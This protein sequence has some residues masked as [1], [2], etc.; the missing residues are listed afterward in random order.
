MDDLEDET[1]RYKNESQR[2]SSEIVRLQNEIQNELFLKSSCEVEKLTIEDDLTTLKHLRK[3]YL[4]LNHLIFQVLTSIDEVNLAELR[5]KSLSNDLD[6]SKFFRNEL[7]EAIR[8]IRNDYET[9]VDNRRNDLQN[10]YSL[11]VN[12]TITRTQQRDANPLFNQQQR[13]QVERL[14]NELVQTLDQN[15]YLRNTNHDMQNS[16]ADLKQKIKDFNDAGR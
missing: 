7:S 4:F 10:R 15:S 14:R 3:I 6:P 1:R 16:I 13:Q 2:L 8:E 12:E 5:S 11:F 9:T